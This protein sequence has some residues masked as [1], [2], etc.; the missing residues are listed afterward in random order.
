MKTIHLCRKDPVHR[1]CEKL[2]NRQDLLRAKHWSNQFKTNSNNSFYE[3]YHKILSSLRLDKLKAV[4][5]GILCLLQLF[6]IVKINSTLTLNCLV[7]QT[8]VPLSSPD[9]QLHSV[10]SKI[11]QEVPYGDGG[12][13][14]VP[15]DLPGT[16]WIEID[17]IN[18]DKI[19][20]NIPNNGVIYGFKNSHII[21][22]YPPNPQYR[23]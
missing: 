23:L 8:R 6:T 17:K 21:Q 7:Q 13:G 1:L 19:F 22:A 2:Y 14:P 15:L 4:K 12:E 11:F 9:P 5:L 10:G 3:G 20:I 16:I 18:V